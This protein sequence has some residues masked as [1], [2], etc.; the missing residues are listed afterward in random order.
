MTSEISVTSFPAFQRDGA[1]LALNLH[2]GVTPE[3]LL[4]NGVNA[5]STLMAGNAVEDLSHE[6]HGKE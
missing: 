1:G 3:H 4:K 6:K 2:I 5:G